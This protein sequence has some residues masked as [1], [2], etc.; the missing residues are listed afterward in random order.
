MLQSVKSKQTPNWYNRD[1]KIKLQNIE[2]IMRNTYLSLK[3]S[4]S[5]SNQ[6]I[7]SITRVKLAIQKSTRSNGERIRNCNLKN[8]LKWVCENHND[9]LSSSFSLNDF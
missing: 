3:I 2:Q 6:T 9:F 7:L 8:T 4:F 5:R 1:N